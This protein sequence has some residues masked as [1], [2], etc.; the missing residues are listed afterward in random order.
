M[1]LLDYTN[2]LFLVFSS[3]LAISGGIALYV[4]ISAI[5]QKETNEKLQANVSRIVA[6]IEKG[7]NL[8][9]I[10]PILEI[11]KIKF[12]FA[13]NEIIRDTLIFDSI[14]GEAELFREMTVHKTINQISYRITV[15]QFAIEPQD[16]YLL[17][18]LVIGSVI[19][20]LI[21]GLFSLHHI[22][23][24][25][26]WDPFFKNLEKLKE[27][28]LQLQKPVALADTEI[29]EFKELNKV[30]ITLS[31][32]AI[33]DYNNIKVFSENASHEMQTP[34]AIIQ[35]N[36][37]EELQ[38]NTLNSA[39]AARISKSLNAVRKLQKLIKT[40]LIFTRIDNHQFDKTTDLSLLDIVN[41]QLEKFSELIEMKK[42][43]VKVNLPEGTLLST[44]PDLFDILI[45][46]L[47]TNAIIHNKSNGQIEINSNGSELFISNTGAALLV[48][49]ERLFDRFYKPTGSKGSMGL[50]LAI[51]KK[52]CDEYK[53]NINYQYEK[54]WHRV[55]I[56]FTIQ[57]SSNIYK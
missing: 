2:R 35:L 55:S 56:A 8:I 18:G 12:D 43:Q 57:N 10:P 20:L 38:S 30:L 17:I 49:A 19:L 6:M 52:I 39:Q 3:I 28:S 21:S 23:S 26:A 31:E 22:I 13:E 1:K 42:I 11:E 53:W 25:K 32:K 54:E 37:E 9:S 15:R 14:E 46:N 51:V 47:F 50:G 4:A 16:F 44:N 5:M 36:L 40:L 24:R 7:E 29:L 34:L 33:K 48:P 41:S 45:S 27:F